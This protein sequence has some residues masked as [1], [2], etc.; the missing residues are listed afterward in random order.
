MSCL[1]AVRP[2]CRPRVP[3]GSAACCWRSSSRLPEW[4]KGAVWPRN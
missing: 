1:S 2:G 3:P 4:L